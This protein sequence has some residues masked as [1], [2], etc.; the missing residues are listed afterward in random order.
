M[1]KDRRTVYLFFM[2]LCE[3]FIQIALKRFCYILFS[4]FRELIIIFFFPCL[5]NIV[6][7]V[8]ETRSTFYYASHNISGLICRR[9]SF[10]FHHR[11]YSINR[12]LEFLF[13]QNNSTF[14]KNI[15]PNTG[16]SLR[17]I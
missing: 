5:D 9:D 4:G 7:C 2:V 12:V 13:Q 3:R 17:D 6:K 15:I 1:K 16:T 14:L 10:R 11:V 8:L